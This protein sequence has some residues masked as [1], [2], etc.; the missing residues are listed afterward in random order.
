MLPVRRAAPGWYRAPGR[1][2][3]SAQLVQPPQRVVVGADGVLGA[4]ARSASKSSC[5]KP[6]RAAR[7]PPCWRRTGGAAAAAPPPPRRPRVPRRARPRAAP[8]ARAEPAGSRRRASG[9]SPRGGRVPAP[10]AAARRPPCTRSAPR[11]PSR[12]QAALARVPGRSPLR[13][14]H[15]PRSV[16]TRQ[17][18]QA[19]ALCGR[20]RAGAAARLRAAGR[21]RPS[22]A[23][24]PAGRPCRCADAE[25][26]RRGEAARGPLDELAGQPRR[27][28]QESQGRVAEWRLVVVTLSAQR[29]EH[30]RVATRAASAMSPAP[31]QWLTSRR[32]ASS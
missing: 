16:A 32:G 29:C 28:A 1:T 17:G 22:V 30:V 23:A 20:R 8:V 3:R 11:R 19:R 27:A 9:V 31:A 6:A 13:A 15:A 24:R 18:H 7:G 12:G 2:R 5:W 21:G 14:R 10:P 4:S 26:G 25:L